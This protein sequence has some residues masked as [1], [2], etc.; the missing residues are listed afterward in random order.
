MG[1]FV[2]IFYVV[3]LFCSRLQLTPESSS[4]KVD[5]KIFGWMI[6]EKINTI[7]NGV[8]LKCAPELRSLLYF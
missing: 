4:C 1:S 5:I 6:L 2:F 3:E 8:V 7:P